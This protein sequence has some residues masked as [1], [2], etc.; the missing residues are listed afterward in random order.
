MPT[1]SI[2]LSSQHS[3][4]TK[5]TRFATQESS[6]STKNISTKNISTKTANQNPPTTRILA[7][8]RNF[9]GHVIH[10]AAPR[11]AGPPGPG[12]PGRL[13]GPAAPDP[14]GAAGRAGRAGCAPR[15]AGAGTGEAAPRGAR[16]AKQPRSQENLGIFGSKFGSKPTGKSRICEKHI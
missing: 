8:L 15:R 13:R 9:C 12:R 5:T 1:A 10:H 4:Y 14:S 2:N 11:L 16:D 7:G 3:F 6:I